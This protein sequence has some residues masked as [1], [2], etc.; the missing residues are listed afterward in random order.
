MGFFETLIIFIF[1]GGLVAT[2]LFFIVKGL[3]N[4]WVNQTKFFFKY[5]LLQKGFPLDVL[6]YCHDNIKKGIGYYDTKKQMLLKGINQ[7]EVNETLW[8]YDQIL[9][10]MNKQ[11]KI[12]EK[13]VENNGK[14][15]IK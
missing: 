3:W 13:E 11:K 8:I 15:K 4:A 1:L 14:S 7:N 12:N 9:N 2:V 5:N 6:G 10:D